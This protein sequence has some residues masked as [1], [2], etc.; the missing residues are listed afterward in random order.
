M[1]GMQRCTCGPIVTHRTGDR[2]GGSLEE[3]TIRGYRQQGERTLVT[4][5]CT[6]SREWTR[7]GDKD[8][9]KQR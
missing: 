9:E 4:S 8:G 5:M 2:A 7:N 3:D 1:M 6:W